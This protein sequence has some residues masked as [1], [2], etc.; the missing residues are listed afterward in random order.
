[1]IVLTLVGVGIF[2]SLGM[3]Q[4]QRAAFKDEIQSVY[5]SR[6]QNSYQDFD[7]ASLLDGK[8]TESIQFRKLSFDGEFDSSRQILVDNKISRGR[9][10]YHLLTPFILSDGTGTVLVNRGWLALG[11]SRDVLPVTLEPTVSGRV[12]G[13]VNIP[14][15]GGFTMGE[16]S[17]TNVWP[18]RIPFIDIDLLNDGYDESLLPF[19]VWLGEDQPGHYH[20]DWNPVWADPDK[21]RAYALQWFAFAFIAILLFFILNLREVK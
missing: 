4:L 6:L 2:V 10:G 21:S 3:W 15:S 5:Q 9:A 8:L 12:S 7:A 17:F 20:R 16:V 14:Q 1:M 13:I 18:Q 11:E 19:I